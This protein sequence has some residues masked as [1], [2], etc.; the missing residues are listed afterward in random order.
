MIS[1]DRF[2]STP[3]P[4]ISH[5]TIFNVP[6]FFG[7]VES[8]GGALWVVGNKAD[9]LILSRNVA[10][11]PLLAPLAINVVFYTITK[12][13]I[14]H[15]LENFAGWRDSSYRECRS[16]S[17]LIAVNGFNSPFEEFLLLFTSI[18][19]CAHCVCPGIYMTVTVKQEECG[20][21][22]V[23]FTSWPALSDGTPYF[24]RDRNYI[25]PQGVFNGADKR[26]A[27]RSADCAG[28]LICQKRFRWELSARMSSLQWWKAYITQ[29][30][31]WVTTLTA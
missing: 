22:A 10:Q 2:I 30:R 3:L 23:R 13:Q 5:V 6:Y 26:V 14:T 11:D 24:A 4:T 28:Q 29:L 21:T 9:F 19:S 31:N 20:I 8:T 18:R 1:A 15:C 17:S 12:D 27:W 7:R 16:T 25:T